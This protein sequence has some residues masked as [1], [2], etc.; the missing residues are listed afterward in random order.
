MTLG[1]RPPRVLALFAA[2]ALVVAACGP[3]GPSDGAGPSGADATPTPIP[4]AVY[5]PDGPAPCH[6][7][8]AADAGNAPYDGQLRRIQAP[9][10]RTVV[11]ELCDPDVT[12]LAKLAV[13]AFAIQDAGWLTAQVDPD[14]GGEQAIAAAMNGTGPFAL[15]SWQRGAS[16]RLVPAETYRGDAADAPLEIRWAADD[17]QRVGG[18]LDGSADAIEGIPATLV[19]TVEA[20]DDVRLVA[21][22][23]TNVLYVGMNARFAPFSDVRVRRAIALG[24]DR[25]ALIADREDAGTVLP[26]HVTPCSIP[27]G[28]EGDGWPDFD[29]VAARALLADAG[30]P[31][32]FT[33]TIQYRELPRA[34][35]PD[36]TGTATALAAQLREHLGIEAALEPIP[37][38]EYLDIVDRGEADGLHLLGRIATVADAARMLDPLLGAEATDEFGDRSTSISA[39]LEAGHVLDPGARREAYRRA[40]DAIRSEVP[41]VPLAWVGSMT[42]AQDQLAFETA[43][44]WSQDRLADLH[45]TGDDATVWMTTG[46]PDGLYC[47]DET[48]PVADL[49]CAQVNEG[50]YGFRKGGIDPIPVLAEACEPDPEAATW[51]CRLRDGVRFSDGAS[52]EAGDV[53]LT[54]AAQWDAEHPLHRGRTGTF[55]RFESVFGGFLHAPADR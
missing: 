36:P 48:T 25:A 34:Y 27:Y 32:G 7:T 19:P 15:E 55:T 33:T 14:R 52:L 17:R 6:Q 29:P 50:L 45:A 30:F 3:D 51:T 46:E 38:D 10:P 20:A 43:S 47:A 53:I 22:P 16:I 31:D 35:L 12:F 2:A 42:A 41:L 49:V 40:N 23:P 5:P 39:A 26:T 1:E 11:F 9:D 28:C 54:F 44:P 13:P 21:R 8:A 24:I 37:D 4:L 18:L